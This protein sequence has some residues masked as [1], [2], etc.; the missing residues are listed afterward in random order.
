MSHAGGARVSATLTS[1]ARY[2]CWWPAGREDRFDAAPARRVR[3]TSDHMSNSTHA[4]SVC[5]PDGMPI[6]L[7]RTTLD[8]LGVL[9]T[10]SKDDPAWGLK[11]CE[12]TGLGSGTV[13]PILD[14]LTENG[15]ITAKQETDPHPGRPAR[16]YYELTDAGRTSAREAWE[17]RRARRSHRFG[18]AGGPA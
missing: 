17:R 11:I 2:R 16:R 5:Q 10:S 4:L 13:Y 3:A 12:E 18:F 7:T 6:R 14:R 1:A 8:V 15:W 9:L